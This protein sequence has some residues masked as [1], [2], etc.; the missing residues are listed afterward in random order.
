MKNKNIL[1]VLILVVLLVAGG[2]IFFVAN[3]SS[4]KPAPKLP[5]SQDEVIP[6][7]SP[8]KIG[9]T[10]SAR[11]DKKAVKFSIANAAGIAG[12]D[13]E[14]SYNAKGNIPRGAIGHLDGPKSAES[15][16]TK[17]IDLG[18]CSS[19]K[20][21]YDEGVTSVKFTLKI[22]MSDGKVYQTEK[23]LDL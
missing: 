21:K 14:I 15:I 8:D 10:V 17:Y 19:G 20:C 9:L 13:Y 3:N 5:S 22:T 2:G 16:E 23:T 1:V 18:T 6:T 11:D 4:Q 7:I 12:V